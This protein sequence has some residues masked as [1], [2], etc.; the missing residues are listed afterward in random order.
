[1]AFVTLYG[2]GVLLIKRISLRSSGLARLRNGF[3]IPLAYNHAGVEK[4]ATA[5]SCK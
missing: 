3:G 5:Y 1:M 4:M 2:G